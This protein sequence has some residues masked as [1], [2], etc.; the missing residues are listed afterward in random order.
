MAESLLTEPQD[1]PSGRELNAELGDCEKETR[2]IGKTVNILS[3]D[4][5]EADNITVGL[6]FWQNTT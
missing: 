6:A 2:A 5:M 4:R 3:Q 1:P